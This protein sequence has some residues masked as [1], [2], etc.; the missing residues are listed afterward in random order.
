[1]KKSTMAWA[2]LLT[3]LLT[4][5]AAA[6]PKLEH[7]KDFIE[8]PAIGPG[9]C[10]HNLFQSNMPFGIISLCTDGEP[11]DLDNYLEKMFNEGICIR[12]VQHKTFLDL[13]KAG[14]KNIGYASSF[15]QRHSWY[16]PQIKIPVGERIARWALATQYGMKRIRWLPPALKEMRVEEGRIALAL[17][18]ET[19]PYND[20]PILGFAIVP[21]VLSRGH[22]LLRALRAADL[23]RRIAAA[24][25]LLK[26]HP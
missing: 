2:A 22:E 9:L 17:D 6:Q 18:G 19:A 21:G 26:E 14:D 20:G 23:E 1:M 5:S 15:D 25:P 7:G 8:A 24:R 16:H 10:L 4:V 3:A 11:Q 12:E 13:R